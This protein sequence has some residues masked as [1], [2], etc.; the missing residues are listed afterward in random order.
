MV[1]TTPFGFPFPIVLEPGWNL[2]GYPQS[3]PYDAQLVVQQLID[4]NSLVKIQDEKG[5]SIENWGLF[6]GWTN[7]IGNFEPGKGF[8][9]KMSLK[10]T[11]WIYQNYPKSTVILPEPVATTHFKPKF[12]GNGVD[13]M[14]INLVGLPVN[15]LSKGDELAIYDGDNCVCAI[16]LLPI[17]LSNRAVSIS[18][19]AS[20]EQGMAGFAEGSPFTLKLWKQTSNQEFSLEPDILKGNST[21]VKHETTMASLEKY[22]ITGLEGIDGSN[23]TEINCYPN[24]FNDKLNIEI[25]LEKDAEV[26]I[27]VLN[28]LGQSVKIIFPKQMLSNGMYIL[29]WN[30]QNGSSQIVTSGFY[31]LKIKIGDKAFYRKIVYSKPLLVR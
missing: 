28:Q 19:S 18:A 15:I 22:A 2:M 1:C 7:N 4:K 6:G 5:N 10:D 29:N 26:E 24:P 20:D 11:L 21:F 17:H 12:E 27:E 9:I 25:N 16:T 8:K 13:H 30:G 14:N 23:L 31:N 3:E